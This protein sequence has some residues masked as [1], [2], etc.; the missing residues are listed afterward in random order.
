MRKG[1]ELPMNTLVVVAIAI[2]ILL[3]VAAFFTGIFGPAGKKWEYKQK[4][5]EACRVYVAQGCEGTVPE[6]V[7]DAYAKWVTNGETTD[8]DKLDQ[9]KKPQGDEDYALKRMCKCLV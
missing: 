9:R 3:A 6:N 1:L 5:D 2:V 7:K 8:Y 4:F